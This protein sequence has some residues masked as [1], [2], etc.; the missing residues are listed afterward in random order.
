MRTLIIAVALAA[1]PLQAQRPLKVV[2]SLPTYAAIAREIVGD[3]GTVTA[4][5]Q[6]DEE[7]HFVQPRPS[8]VPLLGAADLFVTTGLDLELWVPALLDKAANPRVAEGGPGYVAAYAG[9]QLLEVPA[10]LSRSQGDI[11]VYGNPH[12]HTD[13]INA[14]QIARNILAGL[15][16]VAPADTAVFAARERDFE[17]RVLVALYGEELVRLLTPETLLDLAQARRDWDFV[18]HT[19]YQGRPLAARLGGWLQ[20]AA[21]MRGRQMICYHKEWVY[22]SARFGLPCVEYIE[23]KPGIPPSPRHV[24]HVI[25]LIRTQHIPVVFSPNYFDRNQVRQ[26][27]ERTG[28]TG[29]V[30]PAQTGGAPGVD[31][32]VDLVN[33]WVS[34]LTRAFAA[35]AASTQP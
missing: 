25:E 21:V 4:I 15:R 6:G 24:Q 1:G 7:P 3:R 31:R 10:S 18:H 20:Q 22:F 11:H 34:E 35:A 23:P 27:A 26:I 2:T 32:Y 16:R 28:A 30:V 14:I 19:A 33:V 17:R 12:I 29:V 8:F 5:A 9:I 13:P